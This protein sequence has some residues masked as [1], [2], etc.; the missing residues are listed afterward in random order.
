MFGTEQFYSTTAQ[1]LPTLLVAM[2]VEG[3]LLLQR[4]PERLYRDVQQAAHLEVPG[5]TMLRKLANIP[6]MTTIATLCVAFIIGEVTALTILFWKGPDWL[7]IPAAFVV[8]ISMLTMLVGVVAIPVARFADLVLQEAADRFQR[9]YE[10]E[11][12]DDDEGADED[13]DDRTGFEI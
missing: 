9:E 4:R 11:H 3:G 8:W 2:A 5:R 7:S 1:V 13:D 10:R 6:Y 12:G